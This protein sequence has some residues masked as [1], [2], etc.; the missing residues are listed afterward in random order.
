[1]LEVLTDWTVWLGLSLVSAG[2]FIYFKHNDKSTSQ[3]NIGKQNDKRPQEMRREIDFSNKALFSSIEFTRN[4][5][6][7]KLPVSVDLPRLARKTTIWRDE[8]IIFDAPE[9]TE[10]DDYTRIQIVYDI[11]VE[12]GKLL[13]DDCEPVKN[14]LKDTLHTGDISV[15]L[16]NFI[17]DYYPE[18]S[19]AIKVF[20][21]R[22]Q[23]LE[24]NSFFLI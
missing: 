16:A 2:I 8:R 18:E 19:T 7:C 22:V 15:N 10:I 24:F 4:Q 6:V 3:K 17:R 5:P 21:V 23:F 13:N 1:M 20:K 14:H 12:L 11:W 9:N